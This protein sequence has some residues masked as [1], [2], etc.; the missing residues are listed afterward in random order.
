M[1][2][3]LALRMVARR[4]P[5]IRRKILLSGG[6]RDSSCIASR[7]D[8]RL[9]R[10]TLSSIVGMTAPGASSSDG[11]VGEPSRSILL[12]NLRQSGNNFSSS[13]L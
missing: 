4:K 13:G 12:P 3:D 6:G 10:C 5:S 7:E 2:S 1:A 8:G 9:R 11:L